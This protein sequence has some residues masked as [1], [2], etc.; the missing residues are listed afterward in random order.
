M[1][2]FGQSQTMKKFEE[3]NAIRKNY[4]KDINL[5]GNFIDNHDNPRFLHKQGDVAVR[6]LFCFVSSLFSS[7]STLYFVFTLFD[8]RLFIEIQKCIGL[9]YAY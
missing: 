4:Y 3:F 5:L 8:Y 6:F 2:V 1:A 9:C 7:I